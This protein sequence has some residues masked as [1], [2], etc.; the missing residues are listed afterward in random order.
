MRIPLFDKPLRAQRKS[1]AAVRIS[2]RKDLAT[3]AEILGD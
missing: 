3:R 1:I 2:D